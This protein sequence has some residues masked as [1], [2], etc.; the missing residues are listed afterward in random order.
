ML[1]RLFRNAVQDPKWGDWGRGADLGFTGNTN[2]GARVTSETALRLLT[3]YGCSSLIAD[4]IATMPIDHLRKTSTIRQDVTP[5]APWLDRP[6]VDTDKIAFVNQVITSWLLEGHAFLAP[7]RNAF[8]QVVEVYVLDPCVTDVIRV[9]GRAIVV[10]NGQPYPTEVVHAPAF[11]KAGQLRGLNP[12]ANAR[13]S[14]GLGLA[15]EEHGASFFRNGTV[16]SGVLEYPGAVPDETLKRIKTG[17]LNQHR[18]AAKAHL[19]GIVS[20]GG[21]WKPL[22]VSARDAQFLETRQ[23]EAAYIAA[24]LFKVD[25]SMVGLAQS[26]QSLTYQNI[27][28]RWSELIRKIMPWTARFEALVSSLLPRPQYI[29]LNHDAYTRADIKTRFESHQIALQNHWETIPEVRAL[30]DL[31]PLDNGEM[32]PPDTAKTGATGP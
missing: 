21:T 29:K 24:M 16:L 1:G 22:S 19:P 30:E 12:I 9:D 13:E 25:P 27:D 20:G 26:G 32:F 28:Q 6:N 7:V 23:F 11:V 14:I 4:V 8:G 10:Q 15:A 17:W 5:K 31:P 3:V 18:G 2:A